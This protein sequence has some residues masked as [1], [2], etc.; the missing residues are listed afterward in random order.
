M[1]EYNVG[2]LVEAVKGERRVTDRI[3]AGNFP[4]FTGPHLGTPSAVGL[5]SVASY[6]NAGYTLTV[7]EKATP[8]RSWLAAEIG[9][10]WRL[11]PFGSSYN[12]VGNGSNRWFTR[13]NVFG[14]VEQHKLDDH[15]ITGAVK[16]EPVPVTA[17]RVLDD[18]IARTTMHCN[19]CAGRLADIRKEYGAAL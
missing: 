10:T 6:I 15:R 16:L 1:S 13:A 9:E 3:V 18:V 8:P 2:D 19:A 4:W 7:I 11:E 12:V 5:S 17:A 14:G